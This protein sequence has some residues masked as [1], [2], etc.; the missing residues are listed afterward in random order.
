MSKAYIFLADGFEEVEALTAVDLLRRAKIDVRM[1]SISDSLE[2]IGRSRIKVTADRM[3]DERGYDSA[4]LLI[5]PGGMPGTEYLMNHKGL[6]DLLLQKAADGKTYLAAICAA[7]MIFGRLG[8]LEGKKATIY[9]GMEDEL[10]GAE[11]SEHNVV[12]DGRIITSRGA[13][14]AVPFA[15]CLIETL[16]SAEAARTIADSIVYGR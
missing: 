9:P 13:G 5:L 12:K 15:L 11:R 6:R 16:M 10:K 8:L 1:I 4:D 14:T 7:P 2:L 3:F